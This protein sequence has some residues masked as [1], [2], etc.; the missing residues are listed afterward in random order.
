MQHGVL[1][2]PTELDRLARHDAR[3]VGAELVVL[4][5]LAISPLEHV[6]AHRAEILDRGAARAETI[7]MAVSK[8]IGD[9][10]G[11]DGERYFAARRR[12]PASKE[13]HQEGADRGF[14]LQQALARLDDAAA[15]KIV[16]LHEARD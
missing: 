5:D 3:A 7:E 14:D 10:L 11:A 8:G 12:R 13:G 15:E 16:A 6:A 2:L 4:Q 9:L 1:G